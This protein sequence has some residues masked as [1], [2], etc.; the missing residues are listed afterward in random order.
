MQYQQEIILTR[1]SEIK[2]LKTNSDQMEA[3]L[4]KMEQ[5]LAEIKAMPLQY[6]PCNF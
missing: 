5:E 2:T 4:S 6:H 3:Q 1:Q